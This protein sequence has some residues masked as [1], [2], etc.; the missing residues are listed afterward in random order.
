MDS[1]QPAPQPPR[2][3]APARDD[4]PAV[5][6]LVALLAG[7]VGGLDRPRPPVPAR[8]PVL[9]DARPAGPTDA[10]TPPRALPRAV[11]IYQ[12]SDTAVVQHDLRDALT[13]EPVTDATV[14]AAVHP[15]DDEAVTLATVPLGHA[16]DGRYVGVLPHD[17]LTADEGDKLLVTVTSEKQGRRVR[18]YVPATVRRA[19]A[20]D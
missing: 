16:G 15:A 20:N 6:A 17:A 3:P 5:F 10:R 13:G 11:N 14:T 1:R 4:S 2:R 18:K 19:G 9:R 8:Q 7:L 12:Q